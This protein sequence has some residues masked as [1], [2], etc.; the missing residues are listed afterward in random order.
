M[1]CFKGLFGKIT[2]I[3]LCVYRNVYVAVRGTGNTLAYQAPHKIR[4][5]QRFVLWFYT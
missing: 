5:E 3:I 1:V 4:A 2:A